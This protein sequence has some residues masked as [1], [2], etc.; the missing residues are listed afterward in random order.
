MYVPEVAATGN[1]ASTP[2]APKRREAPKRRQPSEVKVRYMDPADLA[3]E[4][5]FPDPTALVREEDA[6]PTALVFEEDAPGFIADS[7]EEWPHT[8]DVIR[9]QV[10][11]DDE[12]GIEG[13]VKRSRNGDRAHGPILSRPASEPTDEE[14]RIAAEMEG[15]GKA[16]RSPILDYLQAHG[17]STASKI[18]DTLDRPTANVSTRLRQLER[19]GYVRRTGRS[20]NEAGGRGGPRIEWELSDPDKSPTDCDTEIATE[21]TLPLERDEMR[22]AYF[23]KL[24]EMIE[25]SDAPEHLFDRIERI[26]G[27][28]S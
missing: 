4:G 6:D 15:D 3:R 21:R 26:V 27:L 20:L 19:A 17:P 23:D 2:A 22:R 1:N 5:A 7:E 10:V 18:G 8:D 12:P 13:R 28:T 9:R 16:S 24:L 25:K 11:D 14:R